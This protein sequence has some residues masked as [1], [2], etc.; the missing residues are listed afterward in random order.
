MS[1]LYVLKKK[2]PGSI[3]EKKKKKKMFFVILYFFLKSSIASFLEYILASIS[4]FK[5]VDSKFLGL[6]RLVRFLLRKFLLRK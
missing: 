2:S 6:H 1:C 3:F 4:V 5:V